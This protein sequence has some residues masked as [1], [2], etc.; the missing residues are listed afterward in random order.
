MMKKRQFISWGTMVCLA[1][2]FYAGSLSASKTLL[3]GEIE[4]GDAQSVEMPRLPGSY[5]RA[6]SWMAPEGATVKPGDLIV[7]LDP[8]DLESQLEQAEVRIET[9]KTNTESQISG[10]DLRIF[11]AETSL[12]RLES[13]LE[14]ARL[15]ATVP[16]ETVPQ[17]NFERNQLSLANAINALERGIKSLED[18]KQAK[19]EYLPLSERTMQKTARDMETIKS[20]LEQVNFYAE[21]PGLVIY[22]VNQSTG[23]KIFPGES[24]GSGTTILIVASRELLQFRFWVHETD[25]RKVQIDDELMVCPDALGKEKIKTKVTWISNQATTRDDWSNAGYFELV[26]KPMDPVPEG[27]KPG[28]SVL[29]ELIK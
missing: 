22:G 20:A 15:G 14:V 2:G 28:M 13:S 19:A 25:I 6:I 17:L 8:G 9:E 7:Q 21:Q 18:A 23:L 1:V 26:A 12:I 3:T 29:G 5:T 16:R 10:H 4:D 24:Y 11:D 27:Y